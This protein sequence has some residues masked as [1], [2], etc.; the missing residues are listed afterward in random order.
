MPD[1]GARRDYSLVG[2]QSKL[3]VEHGLANAKWYASPIPRERLKQLMKRSDEPAIRDT[4][5]WFAAFVGL[6]CT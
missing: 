2:D 3:A 6:L 5:I 1:A 4:I